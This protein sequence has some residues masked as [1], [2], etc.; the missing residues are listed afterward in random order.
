M[1][2]SASRTP[3]LP[4]VDRGLSYA[5]RTPHTVSLVPGDVGPRAVQSLITRHA[6]K[7]TSR[8][9]SCT[10]RCAANSSGPARPLP[11]SLSSSVLRLGSESDRW[12]IGRLLR[13]HSATAASDPFSPPAL[14]ATATTAAAVPRLCLRFKAVTFPHPLRPLPPAPAP[15]S[16]LNQSR[17]HSRTPRTLARS[18]TARRSP[19]HCADAC[20]ISC[21]GRRV[22][23]VRPDPADRAKRPPPAIDARRHGRRLGLGQDVRSLSARCVVRLPSSHGSRPTT[24]TSSATA[25]SRT[26]CSSSP[27]A[28]PPTSP[29]ASP[30]RR[31]SPGFLCPRFARA[32]PW[33]PCRR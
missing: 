15:P 29:S 19:G 24:P 25:P 33:M 14:R 6:P 11:P 18:C 3:P 2:A 22:A 7:A 1:R 26:A 5:L 32:P 16:P 10:A 30:C 27:P 4:H 12:Y 31:S 8:R 21:G 23:A 17:R 9:C 20:S 13:Q 28:S